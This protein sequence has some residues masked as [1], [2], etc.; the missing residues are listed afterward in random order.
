MGWAYVLGLYAG[1]RG[2]VMLLARGLTAALMAVA[3]RRRPIAQA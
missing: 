3:R 2:P 1:K